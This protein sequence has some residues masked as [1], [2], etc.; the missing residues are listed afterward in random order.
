M[1]AWLPEIATPLILMLIGEPTERKMSDAFLSAMI[2]NK[3][4]IADIWILP[5]TAV[6]ASLIPPQQ[7]VQAGFGA[8]LRVHL[9][10][11]HGAI[12]AVF[13]VRGGQITGNHHRSGGNTAGAGRAGGPVKDLG[14]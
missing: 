2:W 11:N 6:A 8:G 5:G 12:E 3:R 7:F 13:P 14:A 1:I 9:F 10:Y 4:F